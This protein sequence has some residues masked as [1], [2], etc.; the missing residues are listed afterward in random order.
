MSEEYNY[1]PEVKR[2]IVTSEALKDEVPQW[3]YATNDA[4]VVAFVH[5]DPDLAA[6]APLHSQLLRL[7]K[8]TDKEKKVHVLRLRGIMAEIEWEMDEE[9]YNA[10]KWKK[11]EAYSMFLEMLVC[12]SHKGYKFDLLTRTRKE[13]TFPQVKKEKKGWFS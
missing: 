5:K 9:A 7:T 11:L 3:Q 1:V 8:I 10:G 6:L 4:D 12:D 13:V 2:D